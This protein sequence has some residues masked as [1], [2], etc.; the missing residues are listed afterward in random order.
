MCLSLGECPTLAWELS[1]RNCQGCQRHWDVA[2]C[3][4]LQNLG[5][6]V[7]GTTGHSSHMALQG[8]CLLELQT[9]PQHS[10][11]NVLP[12]GFPVQGPL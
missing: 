8:M 6:T 7:V 1:S 12:G 2:L 9:E 10:L 5:L 4:T 3:R 11:K